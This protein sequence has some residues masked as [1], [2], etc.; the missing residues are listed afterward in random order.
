LKL[1]P[2]LS[3]TEMGDHTIPTDEIL[4]IY[5]KLGGEIITVGSDAHYPQDLGY[6]LSWA[7]EKAKSIGFKYIASYDQ[8]KPSFIKIP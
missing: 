3:D 8:R 5:Y 1:T 2:L 4:K 7:F 6:K